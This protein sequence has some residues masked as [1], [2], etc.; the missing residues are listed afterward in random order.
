M[1]TLLDWNALTHKLDTY[2]D[3][4][5]DRELRENA[6]MNVVLEYAL[7]LDSEEIEDAITDGGNDRGIDAGLCR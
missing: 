5:D 6:F 7:G 4:T 3:P 2:L 1:P